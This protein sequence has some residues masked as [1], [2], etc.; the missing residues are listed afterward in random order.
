V[1]LTGVDALTP[2]ERQ[3]AELAADGLSNREIAEKLFVTLK[4]VEWHLRN[5]FTKLEVAS[6]T[7]LRA[8]LLVEVA[9]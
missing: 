7:E 9:A 2:R 3:V 1:A 4:T 6:R 5:A 8:A